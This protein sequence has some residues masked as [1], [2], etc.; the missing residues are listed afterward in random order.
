MVEDGGPEANSKKR[1]WIKTSLPGT[2]RF[3]RIARSDI[4]PA[5]ILEKDL[6]SFAAYEIAS[7]ASG[8]VSYGYASAVVC[9]L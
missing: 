2:A 3:A 5:L 6:E 7:M 8:I 4:Y 9:I 1:H